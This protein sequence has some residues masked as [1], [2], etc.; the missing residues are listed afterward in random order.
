ME[1]VSIRELNAHL[2]RHLRRVRSGSSLGISVRGR[3][4]AVIS[5]VETQ[6]TSRGPIGSLPKD[7]RTGAEVS[8]PEAFGLFAWPDAE[9]FRMRSSTLADDLLSF[10]GEVIDE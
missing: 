7:G 9:L 4:I 5:P 10:A 1:I 3:V 8:L 2:T 6:L